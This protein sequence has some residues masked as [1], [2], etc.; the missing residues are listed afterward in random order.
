[1]DTIAWFGFPP[2]SFVEGGGLLK[3]VEIGHGVRPDK[4]IIRA[5]VA[6]GVVCGGG[7]EGEDG[8]DANREIGVPARLIRRGGAGRG[9]VG[10]PSRRIAVVGRDGAS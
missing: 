9:G 1:V 2:K 7:A 8:K 6:V 10:L 5:W 3:D 4:T